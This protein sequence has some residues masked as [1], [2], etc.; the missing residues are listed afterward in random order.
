MSS[1]YQGLNVHFTIQYVA[2]PINFKDVFSNPDSNANYVGIEILVLS[3]NVNFQT[4]AMV[5]GLAFEEQHVALAVVIEASS[6]P[7]AEVRVATCSRLSTT[8][9]IYTISSIYTASA[10]CTISSIYTASA[11]YTT[12]SIYTASSI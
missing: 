9:F 4:L 3:S 6:F 12:S 8:S 7:R 11:I 5:V 2:F 1:Y 10:I